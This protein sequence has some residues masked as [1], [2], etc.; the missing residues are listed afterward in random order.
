MGQAVQVLRRVFH[1]C[2]WWASPPG[3]A[4]SPCFMQCGPLRLLQCE[5][6]SC[7]PVLQVF[8]AWHAKRNAE[9]AA[10]RAAAAEERRKKVCLACGLCKHLASRT[11]CTW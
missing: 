9:R 8:K 1:T 4:A 5:M 7:L 10:K 11:T 6:M 3:F 2:W